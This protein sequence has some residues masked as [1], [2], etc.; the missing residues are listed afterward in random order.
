MVSKFYFL[1]TNR[2]PSALGLPRP[3]RKSPRF[4]LRTPRPN[5]ATQHLFQLRCATSPGPRQDDPLA[6]EPPWSRSRRR[7]LMNVRPPA[8]GHTINT[9]TTGKPEVIPADP[10]RGHYFWF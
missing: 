3:R 6:R 1:E 7:L 4:V 8:T 5:D 2:D 10:S 9:R